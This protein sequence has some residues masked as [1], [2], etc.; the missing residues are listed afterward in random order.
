ML[1]TQKE[2]EPRGKIIN[3]ASL[4]SF[5]GESRSSGD[6]RRIESV[7]FRPSKLTLS[8]IFLSTLPLPFF[9]RRSDRPRLCRRQARYPWSHQRSLKRVG[10]PGHQ[11]QC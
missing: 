5:Q 10:F 4:V 1:E 2:G 8:W 11:R 9:F 7:G 6:E 3:I